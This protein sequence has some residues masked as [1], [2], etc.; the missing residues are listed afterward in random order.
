MSAA[1]GLTAIVPKIVEFLMRHPTDA[2]RPVPIAKAIGE[3][4]I[5]G[6]ARRCGS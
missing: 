2:F 6:C 1:A 5:R 3:Q 4:D